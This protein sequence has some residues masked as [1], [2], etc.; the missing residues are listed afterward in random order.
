MRVTLKDV[1]KVCKQ[2]KNNPK[3]LRG[4]LRYY[5]SF[6]ENIDTFGRFFFSHALSNKVPKFHK[7]I[8]EI[9]L[10]NENSALAAPR[11]HAKSTITG[12]VFL[13]YCIVNDLEKYIV[14]IS[15]SYSKTVQFLT[16]IRDEFKNNIWLKFVYGDLTPKSTRDDDGKDREDCF[17][18]G[19]SRVEA[20]SFEKNIRGFKWK[21]TRPTLI[22]CDDIESDERV[23]NP[24][25]RM[26]DADKLNRVIIPSL[27]IDGRL[28]FIGTILHHDSLLQ[29]KLKQYSGKVF[30]AEND[31]GILWPDRFTKKKLDAIKKD[32][33]SLAYQKEYM[34]NPV[35]NESSII[36]REWITDSFRKDL[37][38]E[39]VNK[40]EF[41]YKFLGVDFAFSDRITADS[42][43]FVSIG[44]KDE[45]FYLLDCQTKKGWSAQEQLNFVKHT[46]HPKFRY[47]KIGLEE[48]S[49]KAISKDLS[50][51]NL[52]FVLF[53]TSGGDPSK[54]KTYYRDYEFD[55][56]RHSVGKNNLILRL[57]TAFENGRF[58]IPFKEDYEIVERL[59]AEC[60]SFALNDG[61]LVE[62]GV[63]PDIPIGL[64]YCLELADNFK[65]GVILF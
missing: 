22:I 54:S 42:S 59:V 9:L 13:I 39:D 34:N 29:K 14:Y 17:D 50:Q 45:F 3:D 40:I 18:V 25:L 15:Q 21:H 46:L 26:K 36:K 64:G 11:G 6:E 19:N 38:W 2:I 48:N 33:G 24:D 30:K 12:L 27:D 28:K 10:T 1:Y 53:W 35:D 58:I 37:S 61:K 62:S 23:L 7:E 8:Y 47:D 31:D 41:D 65:G 32:I 5:F 4:V 63:H 43:A 56:K 60:T 52:P 20:A 44:V 16:P 49:I 55:G 57:S 51:Y